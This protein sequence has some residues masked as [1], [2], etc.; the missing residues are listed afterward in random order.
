VVLSVEVRA[1]SLGDAMAA[2]DSAENREEE[3]VR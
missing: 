3:Q 2:E 1:K